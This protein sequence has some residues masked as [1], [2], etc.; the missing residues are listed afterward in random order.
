MR[1]ARSPT[2][3][4]SS[5]H[6]GRRRRRSRM[7][8]PP[9]WSSRGMRPRTVA[10]SRGS[11]PGSRP[12]SRPWRPSARRAAADTPGRDRAPRIALVVGGDMPTLVPAVLRLLVDGLAADP[13]LAAMT[14]EAP[15]PS[16]L[17]MA[18]RPGA[19][20]AAIDQI[21][22][23]TGRRSLRALLDF[24]PS[25]TLPATTWRALDP[26]GVTLLDVDTPADIRADR[27]MAAPIEAMGA[28]HSP[29]A[30][31]ATTATRS[32]PCRPRGH[33]GRWHG[34][35]ACRLSAAPVRRR[36]QAIA[37]P[38]IRRRPML[39]ATVALLATKV[40]WATC[41]PRGRAFSA[42]TRRRSWPDA[43]HR[44][45]NRAGSSPQRRRSCPGDGR[46][47]GDGRI[48]RLSGDTPPREPDG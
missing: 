40:P 7:A 24:V 29:V 41:W 27:P 9:A 38:P 5:S 43:G 4:S 21:L 1:W 11:P 32:T 17:P 23:S 26:A 10:R 39:R 47:V 34:G 16:P 2:A 44:Y 45:R 48:H 15:H 25:A 19:A 42:P 37:R 13:E 6:R 3:S 18:V 28:F 46:R 35:N 20:L 12:R 33:G 14:L 8:W 36:I 30:P 31:M 22:G